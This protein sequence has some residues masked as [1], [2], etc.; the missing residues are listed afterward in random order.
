MSIG[1]DSKGA[2][3]VMAAIES[4]SNYKN[5]ESLFMQ[6]TT[7]DAKNADAYYGLGAFYYNVAAKMTTILNKLAD[8]YSKE[9]TKKYDAIKAE[10]FALF[11]KSLPSFKM[12]ESLNPNDK[13]CLI[14]LKEIYA[15][16]GDFDTSNEF[17]KRLEVLE[18]GGKNPTSFN[19]N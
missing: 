5:A 18:N 12:S 17:K 13:N 8:D 1:K 15:R 7:K 2:Y 10:V 3:S 4:N 6:A 14:A 11:D 16:K 19:K 9:G